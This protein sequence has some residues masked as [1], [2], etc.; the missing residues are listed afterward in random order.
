MNSPKI[1]FLTVLLALLVGF[2]SCKKDDEPI[3]PLEPYISIDS[4][5][6]TSVVQFQE[7]LR[8][9]ISYQDGDGDLGY[10][11]PDSSAIFVLDSRLTEPDAYHLAPLAPPDETLPI[12]GTIMVEL[13]APFK[14]GT[15]GDEVI[16]Y[17][18]TIRDRAGNWSNPAITPDI[19]ITE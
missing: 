11:D 16:N 4:V 5:S 10:Y 13:K 18:V 1:S 19:T 2:S 8:I 6:S 7:N 15:G 14:L 9:Y 17:T 12:Q 3:F